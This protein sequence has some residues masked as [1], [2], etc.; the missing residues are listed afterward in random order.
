ML[1]PSVT[2]NSYREEIDRTLQTLIEHG[3]ISTQL[4]E[5]AS[6]SLF[7]GGKRI[8]PV[9]A[10]SFCADLGGEPLKILDSASALELLH[11]SSLIHDDLPAL[12][13]D[14][15]RRGRPSCHKQFGEAA[16][17]LAG[18]L[19]ISLAFAACVRSDLSDPLRVEIV[20]ELTS[21]FISLCSGQQ[22]D[23]STQSTDVDLTEIHEL[24]TGAL[25]AAAMAIGALG[26]GHDAASLDQVKKVG[27]LIG[28]GFQAVDDL[29]DLLGTVQER[30]RETRS[31]ARNNKKT[32][33]TANDLAEGLDRMTEIRRRI[34]AELD[35]LLAVLRAPSRLARTRAVI[36]SIFSRAQELIQRERSCC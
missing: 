13:N 3:S 33:F 20:R 31:D 10:L 9:L 35:V 2:D 21:A 17:L 26:A 14:D 5:V 19:L 25:F 18:D 29:I 23:V 7:P 22:L 1:E 4:R 34:E 28:V 16:A 32:L 24:K 27:M 8:R 6:Y 36:S 30:G 15:M 12:D 11:A